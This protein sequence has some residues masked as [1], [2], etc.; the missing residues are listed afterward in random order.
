MNEWTI[1]AM[2]ARNAEDSRTITVDA[3]S[4]EEALASALTAAGRQ[5]PDGTERDWEVSCGLRIVRASSPQEAAETA[6]AEWAE[7]ADDE[8][9]PTDPNERYS[10]RP[11][12]SRG[13]WQTIYPGSP[14]A[15]RN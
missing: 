11:A 7:E 5:I 1:T 4:L 3:D 13:R 15:R 12:H 8:Y 9:A 6:G 2:P 14:G 10:V